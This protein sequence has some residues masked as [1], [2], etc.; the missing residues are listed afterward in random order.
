MK[1]KKVAILGTSRSYAEAPFDDPDYEIWT[2]NEFDDVPRYDR[3]F[4]LHPMEVQSAKELAW[5]FKDKDKPIYVLEETPLVSAGVV[6]PKDEILKQP[7]AIEFF[8]CTFAYEIALAIYEGFTTIGL[9]GMN[10]ESGSPR[11]RTIESMNIL[12]WLGVAKGRGIEVIWDE[13]PMCNRYLY[14]YEYTKEKDYVENWLCRLAVQTIYRVGN[15]HTWLGG[16]HLNIHR[17]E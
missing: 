10:I 11:E 8:S 16:D 9:W 13:H 2:L 3:M 5:L 14:G 1:K 12:W 15:Q 17:K 7:W 4:E 6:Y